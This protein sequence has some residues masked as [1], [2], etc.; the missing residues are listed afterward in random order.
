MVSPGSGYRDGILPGLI[1]YL[2]TGWNGQN[3][4]SGA[5]MLGTPWV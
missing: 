2:L 4:L 3:R 5:L 1:G